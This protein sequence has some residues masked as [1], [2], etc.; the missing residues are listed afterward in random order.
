MAES[1][2]V[3]EPLLR[4]RYSL[5]HA[6]ASAPEP[7]YWPT[8]RVAGRHQINLFGGRLGFSASPWSPIHFPVS[9]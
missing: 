4:E 9:E 8:H 7:F 3:D 5:L 6:S 1:T 2:R